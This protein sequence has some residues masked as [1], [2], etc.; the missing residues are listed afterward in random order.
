MV[1]VSKREIPR[2]PKKKRDERISVIIVSYNVAKL[3][4]KCLRSLLSET[5]LPL[6]IWVVDNNSDDDSGNIVKRNFKKVN[7]I[8]NK[9]NVGFASAVNQALELCNGDYIFLLNPDAFIK[10]N[11]IER[12][13]DFL[14]IDPKAGAVAPK[15]LYPDNSLQLSCRTFPSI[16]TQFLE[17]SYLFKLFPKNKF[18]GMYFMSWW[19]HNNM[20]EIDWASGSALMIRRKTLNEVGLLDE[21]MFMYSEDI[22]WCY[23]CRKKG[24]KIY[25]LPESIVIHYD[26]QSAKI[27]P[28]DRLIQV[29]ESRYYFFR[30]H[31]F[32]NKIFILKTIVLLGLIGRIIITFLLWLLTFS[33]KKRYIRFE[34]LK[35]FCMAFLWHFT[36]KA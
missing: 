21:K 13:I 27:S 33:K 29:L 17:S 6:D 30:K 12:M 32:K 18:F 10:K 15:I 3:L 2:Y 5:D 20:K 19:D 4:E 1:I 22:D 28:A 31:G 25:Y 7:L 36:K 11:S 16:T 14:R 24:W 26:A 34:N 35:N 23:R 9:K 8:E